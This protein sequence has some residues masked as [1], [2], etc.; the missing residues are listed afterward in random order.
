MNHYLLKN[1]YNKAG[2]PATLNAVLAENFNEKDPMPAMAGYSWTKTRD[3]NREYPKDLFLISKDKSYKFDYI[4]F[5]EGYVISKKFKEKIDKFN[6]SYKSVNLDV[7]G[8]KNNKITEEEY[9]FIDVPSSNSIDCIDYESSSFELDKQMIELRG[10]TEQKI[11]KEK[12]Y[13]GNIKTYD[14]LV[15]LK[16]KEN[17]NDIFR[18][19][20]N[21]IHDL[22][23][24]ENFKQELLND[25]IYGI[26]FLAFDEMDTYHNYFRQ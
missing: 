21:T 8:W 19:K 24:S 3:P 6:L 11:I 22:V 14:S 18:I 13:Y 10:L 4:K 9:F 1:D 15:L 12:N 20:D 2:V 26:N 23:C 17:G 7:I 5:W 25:D 16:E